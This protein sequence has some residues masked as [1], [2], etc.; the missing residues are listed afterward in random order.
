MKVE[1]IK[2]SIRQENECK[3][4]IDEKNTANTFKTFLDNIIGNYEFEKIFN[5]YYDSLQRQD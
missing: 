1:D 2:N 4:H 3:G 5:E